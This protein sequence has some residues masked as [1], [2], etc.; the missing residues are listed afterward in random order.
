MQIELCPLVKQ[1]APSGRCLLHLEDFPRSVLAA[2]SARME[3]CT[4]LML[5]LADRTTAPGET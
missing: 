1:R 3:V 4:E 2:F 5:A